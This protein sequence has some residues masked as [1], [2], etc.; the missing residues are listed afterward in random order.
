MTGHSPGVLWD[1]AIE[2]WSRPRGMEGKKHRLDQKT[3]LPWPNTASIL[4]HAFCC[5]LWA[6][7]VKLR[8]QALQGLMAAPGFFYPIAGRLGHIS[9]RDPFCPWRLLPLGCTFLGLEVDQRNGCGLSF[10]ENIHPYDPGEKIVWPKA[11]DW[12]FPSPG[13]VSQR[14]RILNHNLTL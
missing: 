13:T 14:V 10:Q 12:L 4:L 1:D 5:L 6:E 8:Q 9:P 7:L 11:W 2:V 3:S